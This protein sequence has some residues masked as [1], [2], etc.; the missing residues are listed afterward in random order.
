MNTSAATSSRGERENGSLHT[1]RKGSSSRLNVMPKTRLVMLTSTSGS[2]CIENLKSV[3]SGTRGKFPR[4]LTRRL[5]HWLYAYIAQVLARRCEEVAVRR[6]MKSPA[7][8]STTCPLCDRCDR[9]SRVGDRFRCRHC[10]FSS[11]ADLVAALNLKR[12]GEAGVC[13]VCRSLQ[14]WSLERTGFNNDRALAGYQCVSAAGVVSVSRLF[15]GE[16]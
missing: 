1:P 8:T 7:Y 5:S 13:G 9:R 2:I 16:H 6:V 10:G 15:R 14:S 11:E 3:R 4:T 12:L